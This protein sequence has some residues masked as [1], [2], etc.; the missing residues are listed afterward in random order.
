MSNNTHR[1]S[2]KKIPLTKGFFALVSKED[3][4]K[5]NKHKWSIFEREH[6]CYA[7]RGKTINGKQK[8]ILM[9][10]EILG[11][12][13]GQICDHIDRNGLNNVRENLRICSC[14]ENARNSKK[15]KNN[16]SGYKGVS[17]SK[18][19]NKWL[20]NI[21]YMKRTINLGYF[22]DIERAAFA[23]NVAAKEIYGEFANLNIIFKYE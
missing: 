11:A 8:T 9:H 5:L 12:K 7:Q 6:T 16:T 13:K 19:Q 1:A 4:D 14:L 23:Y 21:S 17:W 18:K 22:D 20:A 3:F 15:Q 10:R 2:I